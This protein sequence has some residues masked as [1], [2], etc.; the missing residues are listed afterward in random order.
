MDEATRRNA[1]L[2]FLTIDKAKFRKPA[3]PGDIVEISYQV[4]NTAH[5]RAT[6]GG[7][8]RRRASMRCAHRQKPV[9]GAVITEA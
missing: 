9:V 1:I 2:Y 6:C 4:N 3:M 5:R 8:A 7:T